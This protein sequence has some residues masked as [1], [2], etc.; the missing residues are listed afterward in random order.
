MRGSVD[1][2]RARRICPARALR[3]PPRG[4]CRAI[5]E[6]GLGTLRACDA[7]RP[8]RAYG[9]RHSLRARIVALASSLSLAIRRR[10]GPARGWEGARHQRGDRSSIA[11]HPGTSTTAP[12]NPTSACLRGLSVSLALVNKGNE[13]LQQSFHN[14]VTEPFVSREFR[15]CLS[16]LGDL[17]NNAIYE[18]TPEHLNS[19]NIARAHHDHPQDRHSHRG[20]QQQ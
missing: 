13:L 3:L 10:G 17:V 14:L 4:G 16:L 19:R 11:P 8:H 15:V 1:A 18:Y 6:R 12:R 20:D 7:W 5:P 9:Y 2:G